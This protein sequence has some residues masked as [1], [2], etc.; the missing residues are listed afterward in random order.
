MLPTLCEGD[1]LL[2]SPARAVRPGDIVVLDYGQE[3]VVHRMISKH[4]RRE[5]GDASSS[6]RAFLPE[7]VLGKVVGVSRQGRTVD[8]TCP[9]AVVRGRI[10]G[11]R[12]RRRLAVACVARMLSARPSCCGQATR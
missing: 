5:M 4:P 2:V 6:A 8:L 9:L 11:L 3:K 10:I 1:W 12:S 7:Q